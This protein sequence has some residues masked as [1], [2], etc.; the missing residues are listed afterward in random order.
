[1][2]VAPKIELVREIRRLRI[3]LRTFKWL[4]QDAKGPK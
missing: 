4:L 2:K 1:M 3:V